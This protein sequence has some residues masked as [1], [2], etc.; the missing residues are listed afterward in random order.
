MFLVFSDTFLNV[1]FASTPIF[2]LKINIRLP[3]FS[4]STPVFTLKMRFLLAY[5]EP[6][7]WVF[8][9][10]TRVKRNALK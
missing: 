6:V 2:E 5:P 4:E 3:N 8:S 1:F 10:K 7:E 9:V